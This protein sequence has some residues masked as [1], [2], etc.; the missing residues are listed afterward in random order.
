M[1]LFQLTWVLSRFLSFRLHWDRM[2]ASLIQTLRPDFPLLS[3]LLVRLPRKK[4]QRRNV[5]QT[6]SYTA[7]IFAGQYRRYDC[8][9]RGRVLPS[10]YFFILKPGKVEVKCRIMK[11]LPTCNTQLEWYWPTVVFC[12]DRTQRGAYLYKDDLRPISPSVLSA[13]RGHPNHKQTNKQKNKQT[14]ICIEHTCIHVY[15]ISKI[16]VL[17]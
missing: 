9:F 8:F 2:T 3:P 15:V 11:Y 6:V 12:S 13:H 14:V 5:Q 4:Q 7:I 16:H 10:V 1:F 17:K